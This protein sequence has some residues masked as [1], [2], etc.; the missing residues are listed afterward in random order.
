MSSD[1]FDIFFPSNKENHNPLPTPIQK[2]KGSCKYSDWTQAKSSFLFPPVAV[3]DLLNYE[4]QTNPLTSSISSIDPITTQQSLPSLHLQTANSIPVDF[5]LLDM[6]FISK[7]PLT[8]KSV[9]SQVNKNWMDFSEYASN[10]K[11]TEKTLTLVL[12]NGV[13]SHLSFKLPISKPTLIAQLVNMGVDM[14][15]GFYLMDNFGKAKFLDDFATLAED[16]SYYVKS[17]FDN[18]NV[19]TNNTEK[20]EKIKVEADPFTHMEF[21]AALKTLKEGVTMLKI[22]R[23]GEGKFKFFQLSQDQRALCWY[24]SHKL[25]SETEI[26]LNN[27]KEI[28]PGHRGKNVEKLG[29][30]AISIIGFSVRYTKPDGKEGELEVI[31][32]DR[33]EFDLVIT[34]L[35]GLVSS[36]RGEKI[37]KQSMLAHVKRFLV[38]IQDNKPLD[39]K[40][41]WEIDDKDSLKIEDYVLKRVSHEKELFT[42]LENIEKKHQKL[43]ETN[44][45]LIEAAMASKVK[46]QTDI[47]EENIKFYYAR[48]CKRY[49]FL[50]QELSEFCE[51]DIPNL[52]QFLDFVLLGSIDIKDPVESFVTSHRPQDKRNSGDLLKY[53]D[54]VNRCIWRLGLELENLKDFTERIKDRL[55]KKGKVEKIADKVEGK[56]KDKFNEIG[57]AFSNFGRSL[58]MKFEAKIEAWKDDLL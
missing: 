19:M 11:F 6:G 46:G 24:S 20:I 41:L 7:T 3:A 50:M 17:S 40:E 30:T 28:K 13:E 1:P 22:T 52:K 47:D 8:G 48:F 37:S 43:M 32:K 53:F 44:K 9:S 26:P 55:L 25:R 23:E 16:V 58:S 31:C 21:L 18:I 57:D 56:I 51:Q 4:P 45:P 33:Q 35:K 2:S 34:A 54:L 27:I 15:K 29:M 36:I 5:D 14:D 42:A 49:I 38:A 12:E 39:C 10:Q